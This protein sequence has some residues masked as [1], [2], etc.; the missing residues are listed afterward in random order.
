[1]LE[2][3]H[4]GY[5]CITSDGMPPYVNIAE[6]GDDDKDAARVEQPM[7]NT[8][9]HRTGLIVTHIEQNCIHPH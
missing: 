6:D 9:V 2:A 5:S 7:H 1:M 8:G 3:K 4:G